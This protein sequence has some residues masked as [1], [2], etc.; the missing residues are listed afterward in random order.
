MRKVK[1]RDETYV[2]TARSAASSYS[3]VIPVTQYANAVVFPNLRTVMN[4]LLD[5]ILSDRRLEIDFDRAPY[6]SI[7]KALRSQN[8]FVDLAYEAILPEIRDFQGKVITTQELHKIRL[9]QSSILTIWDDPYAGYLD[10]VTHLYDLDYLRPYIG[11]AGIPRERL[12][13]HHTAIRN[14]SERTLHYWIIKIGHGLRVANFIRLWT[15][16]FP[17]N[18]DNLVELVFENFLE[19]TFCRAFQSLPSS[20]LEDIFGPC[21][22]NNGHYSG[23]GLNVMPPLLQG[24]KI[25]PMLRSRFVKPIALSPDPE[26]REW[27]SMR[28]SRVEENSQRALPTRSHMGKKECHEALHKAIQQNS[29]L[30]QSLPLPMEVQDWAQ[31]EEEI[32]EI[33]T[34]FQTITT[35]LQEMNGA[36]EVSYIRPV[37]SCKAAIGV[38][39]DNTTFHEYSS[40]GAMVNLPWGM[41]E[42]GF[43]QSNSLIWSYNLQSYVQIPTSFQAAPPR[44]ADIRVLREATQA[45][46]RGSH[47]GI[48]IICGDRAEQVAIPDDAESKRV[49]ITLQGRKYNVWVEIQ[50]SRI[51]RLFIRSRQPLSRLW[52]TQ[53]RQAFDLTNVFRFSS[54]MMDI[55]I[56]GG[57][58]ESALSVSLIVRKWTD[59]RDNGL[60]RAKPADLEPIL[61][62]WL[63]NRSFQ[64][65]EDLD[66]LTKAAGGSLRYGVLVLSLIQPKE[67]HSTRIR[68]IH[69]SIQRRR[70]AIPRQVIDDVKS[71][72]TELAGEPGEP[73]FGESGAGQSGVP[74]EEADD[75]DEHDIEKAA[76]E[77]GISKEPEYVASGA[78]QDSE[79]SDQDGLDRPA[80][81]FDN[82]LVW[83]LGTKYK[84]ARSSEN[85]VRMYVRHMSILIPCKISEIQNRDV[86]VKAELSPIGE[87][88]PNMFAKTTIES[89]PAS[90]LAIRCS[91]EDSYSG[92]TKVVYAYSQTRS[93]LCKA[94]TLVDELNG[95]DFVEICQRPRR[96]MYVDHR[97]TRQIEAHPQLRP[98]I[99]G[100]YTDDNGEVLFCS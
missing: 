75:V 57:F 83:L 14:A 59:E 69:P 63:A 96:F 42:S 51:K 61:K 21:P 68:R 5:F 17:A 19:M 72:W 88:H 4:Q 54:I 3:R 85:T 78:I 37:G 13:Q 71:L 33:E 65:H 98:F 64:S 40:G 15:M 79:I 91:F 86:W 73:G 35:R 53:G 44:L 67:K 55:K 22:E 87:R 24:K 36:A 12:S 11:Q 94:N 16:T 27:P 32:V 48:V 49:E 43:S 100:A 30:E 8:N 26:I 90:R 97:C 45:L 70:G 50:Q 84:G 9:M 10:F 60:P 7:V 34:W 99:G 20:I 38:I 31:P 77:F 93:M 58:Y 89:D 82:R 66:R 39:I 56:F 25:A 80:P 76:E 74:S 47:L 81:C 29:T 23:M 6:K 95:D 1:G 46:I 62:V 2:A 52:A 41:Q 28:V 18:I 92:Q